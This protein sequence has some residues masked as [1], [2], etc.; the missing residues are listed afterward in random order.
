VIIEMLANKNLGRD[1]PMLARYGRV[2]VVG[3]RGTVEI[4]PRDTMSRD[5]KILGMVLFNATEQEL[6]SIHAA[7]IAAL[8]NG[9]AKPIVREALPLAEARRAHEMVMESGAHGKIVLVP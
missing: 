1:L 3:S 8:E 5:A 4:N 7:L 9:T 6:T 2:V